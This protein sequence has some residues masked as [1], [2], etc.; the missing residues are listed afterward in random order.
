MRLT[1]YLSP[2]SRI[3]DSLSY[4][5]WVYGAVAIGLAMT[6]TDQ[7]GLNIALPQV[8]DYFEVDIPTI[9]WITLGYVVSTSVMLM[10]IGRLA[11]MV[12]RKQVFVGGL[13]VFMCMAVVG[14]T[15]QGYLILIAA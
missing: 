13:V 4:K 12:G 9:Q 3:A 1:A 2:P 5:W 14:R 6:V 11:D 10:P 15:S 8:A 7:S